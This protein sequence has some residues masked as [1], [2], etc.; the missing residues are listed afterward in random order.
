MELRQLRYLEAVV[1]CGGFTRAAEH[2]HVAQSAVSAQIRSLESELG[3]PLLSRTT[4]RVT[5]TQAGELVL[6]RARRVLAELDGTR[7]DLAELAAAVRGR[8]VLGAAPVLGRLDLPA[9]L[10][11]FHAAHPGVDLALRSGRVA[12]LLDLLD[13]GD[14]DLVLGPVHADLPA[15]H[16]AQVLIAEE[17]TLITAPDH[18]LAGPAVGARTVTLD[19]VRDEPFVC[20]PPGSGL[21]GILDT[22]AAAAGL[23][24][25]VPFEADSPQRLRDLVGAGLGVAVVARSTAVGPGTPVAVHELV[26]APPH[27]PIGL[28]RRRHRPLSPAARALHRHL[29]ASSP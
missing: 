10:A 3:A 4:R 12:S 13:A 7:T 23:P 8:V 5:V 1:R 9:A 27:P 25:R 22:A 28:V 19:D 26:P 2:L 29:H 20:L 15:R 11:S 24:L 16:A 6:A 18:R 14:A 17:V 21:R